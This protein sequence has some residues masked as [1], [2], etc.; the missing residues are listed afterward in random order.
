MRQAFKRY[1]L[2]GVSLLHPLAIATLWL[3]MLAGS[4]AAVLEL[5]RGVNVH[6]WLNWSPVEKDGSY[7]WPPYRSVNEWLSGYRDLGD[8][9]PGDVFES[10]RRMG[11][12]Y[13]RLTID[14]GPLLASSGDRRREAVKVI[15]DAVKRITAQGLKVVLN[16]H[17]VVQVPRYS[18]AFIEGGMASEGAAIY[19]DLAGDMAETIVAIGTDRVAFE[20]YNEPAFY[21]CEGQGNPEWQ[22]IMEATVQRIRTVSKELTIVATG[23]CGGS[24]TGLVDLDPSFDDDGIYYSFHFYEPHEFT[25]QGLASDDE[26]LSGLPWP[27]DVGTAET[28]TRGLKSHM[29]EAGLD[30]AKEATKLEAA[31]PRIAQYF[32]DNWG[33]AQVRS[34]FDDAQHWAKR[35]GIPTSRLLMGEFGAGLL[36]GDYSRGAFEADRS[37]YI[38]AVRVEAEDRHIPWAVWEFSNPFGMSVIQ[39][40]GSAVPDQGLLSALGLA[41]R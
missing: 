7:K 31:T 27:A 32:A 23:A 10:I 30:P 9:P 20:P 35:H 1:R 40:G 25:H 18:S 14:P 26:F 38:E 29:E 13:V 4:D 37:R 8:W 21:P 12:D 15:S 16:L 6:E 11:F 2:S 5:H 3:A 22:R 41:T 33:R 17:A 24:I 34:R 36:S 39:R 19:L 28:V